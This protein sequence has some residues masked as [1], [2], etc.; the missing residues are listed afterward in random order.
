MGKKLLGR[1]GVCSEPSEVRPCVCKSDKSF[2]S[3]SLESELSG[4]PP[5]PNELAS[6]S[7]SSNSSSEVI[8]DMLIHD[9]SESESERFSSYTCPFLLSALIHGT[10]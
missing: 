2:W 6:V 4:S 3:S 8:G 1:P 7:S 5:S 9:S 10:V